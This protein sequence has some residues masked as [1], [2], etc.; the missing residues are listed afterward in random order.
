[1][2]HYPQVEFRVKATITTQ[3]AGVTML[4]HLSCFESGIFMRMRL[5]EGIVNKLKW[6][7][8]WIGG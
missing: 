1:M 6:A 5:I 8:L 3:L 7:V 4:L 2:L